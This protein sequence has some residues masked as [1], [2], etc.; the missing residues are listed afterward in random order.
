VQLHRDI[1]I[2]PPLI[3]VYWKARAV[4]MRERG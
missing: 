1:Q 2:S 3:F 4:A